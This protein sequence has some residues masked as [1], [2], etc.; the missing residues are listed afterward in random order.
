MAKALQQALEEAM[1]AKEK[2]ELEPEHIEHEH[3]EEVE[4]EGEQPDSVREHM[5]LAAHL[6]I[7][8]TFEIEEGG[9]ESLEGVA[10]NHEAL[11]IPTASLGNDTSFAQLGGDLAANPLT[12]NPALA[13]AAAMRAAAAV[14]LAGP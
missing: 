7:E 8:A 13:R 12:A 14:K 9:E 4:N 3:E 10:S 2:E 6:A 1:L 5:V 11:E